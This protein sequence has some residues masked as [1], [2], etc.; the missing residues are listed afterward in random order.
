[1]IDS[2]IIEVALK[3]AKEPQMLATNEQLFAAATEWAD[4][5]IL[6]VDTEF[7]RERTYRA[8]LGL[9][10]VSDGRSAWLIDTVQIEDFEPLRQLFK[11]PESL[12]VFHSSSEDLEVLWNTLGVVPFPMIDTQMACAMLGQPLQM[13]YHHTVK[14]LCGL[15]VDK[16]LTRSN[17][18]RRPLK[19]EQLH[20]AA[21]DVVFLPAILEKLR[22]DLM[23]AGRWSWL[24][25]DVNGMVENSQQDVDPDLAYL[26]M[27]N[28]ARLDM[29]SLHLLRDLA[30]WRELTAS[31]RN[32]ARGFVIPDPALLKLASKKPQSLEE[33]VELTELHPRQLQRHQDVLLSLIKREREVSPNLQKVPQMSSSQQRKIKAMRQVVQR[34][35][36]LLELD[37]ALL[38]SRKQLEVLLLAIESEQALPERFTGWRKSII[39]EKLANVIS[40]P[41][42]SIN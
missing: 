37:P 35:A 31:K 21:T 34:E 11:N 32:L 42:V 38:A 29:E 20:Y 6:G 9:V 30:A 39:T 15:E 10:Q 12:K 36:E 26:R 19:P 2:S 5:K 18:I 41:E 40:P 1:M 22:S 24:Q 14:W 33:M 28:A 16:E 13:S 17:W 7:L 25:E 4:C 3:A 23:E 8:E 27:K